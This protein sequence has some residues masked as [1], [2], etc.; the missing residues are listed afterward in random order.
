MFS[1][2]EIWNFEP[3]GNFAHTTGFS[4]LGKAILPLY[5]QMLIMQISIQTD[6][7][8]YRKVL[9]LKK[10]TLKKWVW[11]FET[12]NSTF[13]A[14]NIQFFYK[15]LN[16]WSSEVTKDHSITSKSSAKSG[17]IGLWLCSSINMPQ[18]FKKKIC[19]KN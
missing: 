5:L 16:L 6:N 11:C 8:K 15:M 4:T 2:G 12:L 9:Q 13:Y 7:H 1:I 19:L 14:K 17:R 10:S 18:F 3:T